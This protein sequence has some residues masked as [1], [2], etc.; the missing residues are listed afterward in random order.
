MV[1]NLI[2]WNF[3]SWNFI[4]LEFQM[5]GNYFNC[6]KFQLS[7]ISILVY[8]N[9][10]NF[11]YLESKLS[12]FNCLEFQLQFQITWNLGYL[13]FYLPGILLPGIWIVWNLIVW[14]LNCLEFWDNWNF[15]EWLLELYWGITGSF[16]E[17]L[18]EL[19]WVI[20]GTFLT[21]LHT[22]K[23]ND[24]FILVFCVICEQI[25]WAD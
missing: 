1:G 7:W 11:N 15:I 24:T 17:W 5:C 18:L 19:F 4:H 16:F 10:L 12:V 2:V 9:I 6:L 13:E 8:F 3:N 23:Y 21:V 25:E 20:I 22:Y 14:N